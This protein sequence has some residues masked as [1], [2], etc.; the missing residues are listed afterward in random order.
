MYDPAAD[1]WCVV[2]EVPQWR[3]GCAAVGAGGVFYPA[4]GVAGPG[5]PGEDSVP[6]RWTRCRVGGVCVA[7]SSARGV[8][9]KQDRGRKP[10][11]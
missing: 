2:A 3:Y 1:A 7:T 10:E 4:C 5:H 6:G 11:T 9:E 8:R